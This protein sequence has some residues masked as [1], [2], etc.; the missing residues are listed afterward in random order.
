V[1]QSIY[2]SLVPYFLHV[3]NIQWKAACPWFSPISSPH[4][5]FH[6]SCLIN[7]N[8]QQNLTII[9]LEIWYQLLLNPRTVCNSD[10]ELLIL[11]FRYCDIVLHHL[12]TSPFCWS[13]HYLGTSG[14]EFGG[15]YITR[16]SLSKKEEQGFSDFIFSLHFSNLQAFLQKLPAS[17][18]HGII[19]PFKWPF[20]HSAL[21]MTKDFNFRYQL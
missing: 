4:S 9:F 16:A 13:Y 7:P 12:W 18:I 19:K 1:E 5:S 3:L 2:L 10:I 14:V 8:Y 15:R 20:T 17:Y 11:D 6:S 21:T